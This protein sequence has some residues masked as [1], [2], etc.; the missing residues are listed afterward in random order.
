MRY[1]LLKSEPNT[2][3]LYDQIK[4][5]KTQWDG[6][7]NYQARNYLKKMGKGD[8]CLFYHSVSD[9][10]VVGIVK[11]IKESYPDNTDR[12]GRFLA[13]DVEFY[14]K[15]SMPVSLQKIKDNSQLQH[16]GIIKQKR[17]SVMPIDYKSW[18]IILRLGKTKI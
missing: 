9:K 17:L 14:R 15:F 18:S 11:V 6:V 5:K 4:A 16:L 13:V 2:W 7:R 3:S 10:Q 12:S 1:W 8:L